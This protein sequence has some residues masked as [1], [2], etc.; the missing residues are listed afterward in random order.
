[1]FHQQNRGAAFA[2][3]AQHDLKNLFGEFRAQAQAGLVKQHQVG[4]GHQGP[5]YRQHLLLPTRQQAGVL[6]G[7]L[8]QD[9]EVAVHQRHVSSYR[10]TVL[11]GIGAHQQVVV[12]AEQGKHLTALGHMAQ[13]LLHN[14]SWITRR[15]VL[16]LELDPP[17]AR[18]NDAG[19]GFQDGGLA[20][21]IGAQH[22]GYFTPA[23][24]QAD[25]AY[26][27]NRA[28][29]ALHIEQLEHR[30][31]AHGWRRVA[32]GVFRRRP[33]VSSAVPR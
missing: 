12:H 5:R 22:G 31:I 20:R 4:V 25:T 1:M 32:H 16:A 33:L 26:G 23:H 21:A 14:K 15:D 17:L 6:R 13:T 9:G 2:V 8:A 30:Q 19:D 24:L 18:I 7:P 28:I 29:G 11:A 10:I 3:D 27:F